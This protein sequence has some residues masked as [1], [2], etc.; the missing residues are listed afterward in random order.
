MEAEGELSEGSFFRYKKAIHKLFGIE[1]G[2]HHNKGNTYFIENAE[3]LINPSIYTWFLTGLAA[4]THLA[5]REELNERIIFEQS[6][7]GFNH[8]PPII[9]AIKENRILI[10]RYLL[11]NCYFPKE[12]R[13][14]PYCLKQHLQDWYVIGTISDSPFPFSLSLGNILTITITDTTFIPDKWEEIRSNCNEIILNMST[15]T[16]K[17]PNVSS[18]RY[19]SD[20]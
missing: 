10:V 2:C 15:P 1:I 11:P 8:I 13:I 6:S 5:G 4:L 9:E 7:G 19:S 3:S 17:N 12:I 14:Q 18:I 16:I 20:T